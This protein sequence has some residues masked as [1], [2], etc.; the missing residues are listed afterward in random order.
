LNKVANIKQSVK[1]N[2]YSRNNC[3]DLWNCDFYSD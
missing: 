2:F 1:D 3:W